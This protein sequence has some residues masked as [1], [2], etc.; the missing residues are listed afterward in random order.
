MIYIIGTQ[1][2]EYEKMSVEAINI[3]KNSDFFVGFKHSLSTARKINEFAKYR[4]LEI[5]DS[6]LNERITEMIEELRK[7]KNSVLCVAGNPLIFSYA[8]K[9]ME[10]LNK[11]EYVILPTPSSVIYLCAKHKIWVNDMVL[12]SGHNAEDI[13]TPQ[14]E[15]IKYLN[16]GKPVGYFVKNLDDYYNLMKRLKNINC[17]VYGGYELG[18][19]KEYLFS[20]IPNEFIQL[21]KGR[22]ILFIKPLEKNFFNMFP[23]NEEL[24][25]KNIPVSRDWSR[26]LIINSMNLKYDQIVWDLGSGSGATSIWI[27]SL[28]GN[29]GRVYSIEKNIERYEKLNENVSIYPNI[30][31]INNSYENVVDKIPSPDL[32]H[33]G[34][35][36]NFESIKKVINSIKRGTNF[37][38]AITT[39]ESLNVFSKIDNIEYEIEMYTKSKSK[40][41]G[42]KTTFIGEHVLYI[43]KGVKV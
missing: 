14:T 4:E 42:E 37:V 26:A 22:L 21:K 25:V 2:N 18:T 32:I 9:I 15:T 28:L 8:K 31:T 33:F 24:N 41:I 39:I 38:G 35:G 27:S 5:R 19:K 6:L 13:L 34:G 17:R 40:K 16:A 30:I 12:V 36:I 23:K 43:I 1:I 29:K 7:Y 10:K 11:D 20:F 3:I